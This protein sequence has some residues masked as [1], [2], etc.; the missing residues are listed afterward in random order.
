MV[1]LLL[2]PAVSGA[3]DGGEGFR[4][5]KDPDIGQALPEKPVQIK[6]RRLSD[7]GYTWEIRGDDPEKVMEADRKLRDRFRATKR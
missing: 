7:G 5:R 2:S 4:F 6:L 1:L 3:G